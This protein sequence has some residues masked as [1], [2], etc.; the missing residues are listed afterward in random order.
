MLLGVLGLSEDASTSEVRK[1]G[2]RLQCTREHDYWNSEEEGYLTP[3]SFKGMVRGYAP[4]RIESLLTGLGEPH[5][6]VESHV[7][8]KF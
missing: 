2:K 3:F 8:T 1:A 5:F 6:G 4:P 7:S